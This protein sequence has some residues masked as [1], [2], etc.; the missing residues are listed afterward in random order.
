MHVPQSPETR[1]ETEQIMMVP[2]NIVSAQV[3]VMCVQCP[4]NNSPYLRPVE[5]HY[6]HYRFSNL[7][8]LD[9]SVEIDVA[10]LRSAL[11]AAACSKTGLLPGSMALKTCSPVAAA[12]EQAGH[13]HCAGHA[14]GNAPHDKA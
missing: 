10:M 8:V 9:C 3:T 2:R 13:R 11:A 1:A 12:G 4:S 6:K 7:S 5:H 14:S